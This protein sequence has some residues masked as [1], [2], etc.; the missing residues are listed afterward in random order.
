MRRCF[1]RNHLLP[2]ILLGLFLLLNSAQTAQANDIVFQLNNQGLTILSDNQFRLGPVTL[3]LNPWLFTELEQNE[4][5][6][7]LKTG[8]FDLGIGQFHLTIGRQLNA[9]GPGR[10]T[11]PLLAPLGKGITAEGL[12][13]I[14]YSFTTK[15]LAYK[16]LYAW[17]P[18]DDEFRI[19]LGQRA[20]YD[21]GPFTF[22]FA[23][24]ALA[25]E[26]LPD[27]YY[28]PLPLVPVAVYQ[29]VDD[30]YLHSPGRE[31]ALKIWGE[32][33]LT[34]RLGPNFKL[35]GGYLIDERPLPTWLEDTALNKAEKSTAD[36]KPWKVGY[37]GGGEWNQPLGIK[38]LKLYT[39][40]TRINQ[41]TYTNEDPFFTYTY[42]GKL[43][44]GPLGPD[45]DLLNVELVT[46]GGETWTFALAYSR[47]RQGEGRLGDLWTEQ[48]NPN[49][50]FL[51]GTV[52]TTDQIALTTTKRMGLS[53]QV[54]MTLSLARI[55]NDDH[56]P[57]AVTLR[58]EITVTARVSW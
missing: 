24:T 58:P 41:Y 10:Y 34:L 11:F 9:F 4:T 1:H 22:G 3:F 46:T 50:V 47:K 38:G 20:T 26:R 27:F 23:E 54:A 35:Y 2:I 55:S 17:V 25:K 16:K 45:S 48:P 28:W 36:R 51:T 31:Q 53:D 49:E 7:G 19:L 57:G 14:A 52:E 12:D 5:T 37:Q 32:I 6:F 56:Q 15:R 40:Y 43:L 13:Q 44:G 42:K 30:H 8:G 33:D 21:L 29:L 18:M 39:E